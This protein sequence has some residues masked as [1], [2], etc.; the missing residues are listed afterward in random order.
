VVD[1]QQR[2]EQR[3]ARV[4]AVRRRERRRRAA[5]AAVALV[6]TA[7]LALV[8]GWAVAGPAGA[9]AGLVA[10]AGVLAGRRL[11]GA[12]A[13]GRGAAAW[14]WQAQRHRLLGRPADRV[15]GLD[16]PT[17]GPDAPVP[18]GGP[19]RRGRDRTARR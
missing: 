16:R 15:R 7:G 12:A 11:A 5:L 17:R 10:V 4:D 14:D 13:A 8:L 2:F 9:A 19:G 6:A 3:L 18:G 1:R